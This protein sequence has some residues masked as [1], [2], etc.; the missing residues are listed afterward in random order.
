MGC[1]PRLEFDD[2]MLIELLGHEFY[3][4]GAFDFL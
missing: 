4:S 1:C 3:I 2:I